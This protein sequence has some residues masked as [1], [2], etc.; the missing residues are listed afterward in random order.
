VRPLVEYASTIW[1]P[2]YIGQITQ[3]EKVQKKFTKRIPGCLHLSYADRLKKLELQSLE[4]RRLIADLLM[5]YNVLNN[6]NCLNSQNYFHL[7]NNKS[8]RGHPLKL[9]VQLVKLNVRRF[10]FCNRVVPVW[11]SLPSD[12]VMS[13]SANSFKLKLSK[14][15]LDSFLNFPT[16]YK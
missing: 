14:F 5:C 10:F 1:S 7:N 11:N 6:N 16:C 2:S 15:N 13:P 9:T 3:I 4:H 8:L 12:L